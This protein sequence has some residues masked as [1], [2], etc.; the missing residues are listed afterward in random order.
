MEIRNT[1][2]INADYDS[3]FD[4]SNDIERWPEL[5]DEYTDAEIIEREGNRIHFRLSHTNGNSWVSWRDLDK[6]N[7]RC[8]AERVS[9]MKPFRHMYIDWEY[10]KI[11]AGIE[12]VW[13]QDFAMDPESGISDE[14]ARDYMNSHS[15]VNMQ[16]MKR[17]IEEE[18]QHASA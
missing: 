17:I 5:F 12:M 11:D 8:H 4:I 10:H 3:V 16:T 6:E 2:V 15:Q 18:Y 13:I 1:I 14:K 9:P 7:G